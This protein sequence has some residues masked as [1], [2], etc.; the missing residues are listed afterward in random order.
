MTTITV[1]TKWAMYPARAQCPLCHGDWQ[2]NRRLDFEGNPA[3]GCDKRDC[4]FGEVEV[5]TPGDD[6]VAAEMAGFAD[7]IAAQEAVIP[8]QH[9][10]RMK[11]KERVYTEIKAVQDRAVAAGFFEVHDTEPEWAIADFVNKLAVSLGWTDSFDPY[12]D[13]WAFR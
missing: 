4:F 10:V 7:R 9:L 11:R 1:P 5:G 8:H 13:R 6:F 2:P 3:F 12:I